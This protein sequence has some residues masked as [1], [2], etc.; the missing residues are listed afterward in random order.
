MEVRLN[1]LHKIGNYY[2]KMNTSL[3]D[4]NEIKE[5]FAKEWDRIKFM[6]NRYN[7]INEWWEFCAKKEINFFLSNKEKLKIKRNMGC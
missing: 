4:N 7:N 2:W 1:N 3:L 5:L 6:I